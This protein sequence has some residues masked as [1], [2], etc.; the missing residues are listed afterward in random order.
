MFI[1]GSLGIELGLTETTSRYLM[2]YDI[3]QIR[4]RLGQEHIYRRDG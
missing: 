3:N 4:Q 2:R 1:N